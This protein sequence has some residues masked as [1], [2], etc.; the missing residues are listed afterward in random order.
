MRNH[1][2]NCVSVPEISENLKILSNLSAQDQHFVASMLWDVL[3]QW[4]QRNKLDKQMP[5]LCILQR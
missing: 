4:F 3:V 1:P 2:L 5:Q